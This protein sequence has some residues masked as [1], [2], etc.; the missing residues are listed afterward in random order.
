L[1]NDFLELNIQCI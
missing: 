1:I